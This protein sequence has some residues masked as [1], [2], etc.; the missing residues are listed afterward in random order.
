MNVSLIFLTLCLVLVTPSVADTTA[1]STLGGQDPLQA[2]LA[3]VSSE[4][5]M[6]DI[7][8]LSS[9]AFRGRQTGTNEDRDSASLLSNRFSVLRKH[10]ALAPVPESDSNPL[11]QQ[12]WRQTAP[13]T[14]REIAQT[15]KMRL[16][17][18][19]ARVSTRELPDWLVR[20]VALFNP[21]AAQLIGLRATS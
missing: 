14:V 19:G 9:P 11:P 6:R 13:V 15:L 17:D 18:A 7:A 2:A 3:L 10:R 1:D 21:E 8:D 12:E 4:R 20:I 5:M 16:G